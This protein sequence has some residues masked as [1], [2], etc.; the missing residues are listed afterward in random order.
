[1]AT[2][3]YAYQNNDRLTAPSDTMLFPPEF[4]P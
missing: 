4:I 2:I 1:M 3:I